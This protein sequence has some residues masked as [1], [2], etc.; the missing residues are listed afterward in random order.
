MKNNLS[1]TGK[2]NIGDKTTVAPR[3]ARQ[4]VKSTVSVSRGETSKNPSNFMILLYRTL[5]SNGMI[6][7]SDE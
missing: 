5:D 3:I 2:T 7:L 4:E 6:D 1:E